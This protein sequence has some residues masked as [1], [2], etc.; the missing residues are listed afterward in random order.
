MRRYPAKV[1][2]LIAEIPEPV[3]RKPGVA[4]AN[5]VTRSAAPDAVQ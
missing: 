2:V 4:N 5:N 1:E 3:C